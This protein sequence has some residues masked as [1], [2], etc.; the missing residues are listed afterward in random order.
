MQRLDKLL[1]S[2][3]YA[4]RRDVP[5]L[6]KSGRVRDRA[7]NPITK[8][9][10]RVNAA[11]ILLEGKE[12]D[13]KEGIFIVMHKPVGYTCSHD[14][15]EGELIYDLLPER[16]WS[17]NPVPSSIGR[18]D[19]ETSGVLLIT[20]QGQWIHRLASPKHHVDKVYIADLDRPLDAATVDAFASGTLLLND[21]NTPCLPATL[22]IL[23]E[24]QAR[25]TLTEGRYHQVRRMFA[26]CGNHVLHLHRQAFGSYTVKDLAPG[27]WRDVPD[28]SGKLFS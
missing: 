21:D 25:V 28:P 15:S 3:G 14:S 8:A 26:A 22:E 5:A 17:R 18:L 23:S 6:C 7:G 4:S 24:R 12:L 19:K 10:T 20:D 27:E 11:D 16:W 2:L 9:E 13:H 1:S